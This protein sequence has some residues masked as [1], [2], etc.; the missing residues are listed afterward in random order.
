M[1]LHNGWPIVVLMVGL[2]FALFRLNARGLWGDEVW[3]ASW[4]QQ[5]D[6]PH[7]IL[8][9]SAPPDFPLHF[10]L[11]QI[12]TQFSQDEFWV[13]LPSA[14][15]AA[16]TVLLLYFLGKRQFDRTTGVIAALL[17][18]VA[19]F[20]V[21]YAQE[22]RPYAAQACYSVL[23][24]FFFCELV[25]APSRRA[26]LGLTV[27]TM[28]NLYNQFFALV[29]MLAE[30]V[31]LALLSAWWFWKTRGKVD[32]S[33]QRAIVLRRAILFVT[34]GM[35]A[36]ILALPLVPGY[37][38]YIL[39]RGPGEVEAP[40]FRVTPEFLR[41]IFGLFGS[42]SDWTFWLMA[43]LAVF[44]FLVAFYRRQWFALVALIWLALPFIIL[45]VTQPRH[46]FIPRYFLFVQPVYI[47]MIGFG[48]AQLANLLARV[49]LRWVPDPNSRLG[50]LVPALAYLVLV[51]AAL[52]VMLLQTWQSYW[53]EKTNDWSAVCNYLLTHAQPADAVT[54]DAYIIGLMQWCNP[55][56][57][58]V[59]V[60][61]SL[62]K[63]LAELGTLGLNVW[64]VHIDPGLD[65]DWLKQN[66]TA[67]TRSEWARP[68]LIP[69]R[70]Y[71]GFPFP[72]GEHPAT[73]YYYQ[74]KS[75]SAPSEVVFHEVHGGG[76]TPDYTQVGPQQRNAVRLSLPAK[77]PR[78]LRITYFDL[79]GRDLKISVNGAILLKI[80]AGKSG[81]L[82]VPVD[83]PL[84]ADTPDTF[85]LEFSNPGN[86]IS[87]ISKVQVLYAEDNQ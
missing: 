23:S 80:K 30:G 50:R 62:G 12:T 63:P 51:G 36:V 34:S 47:L 4:S 57:Q 66:A 49:L 67:T 20:H 78:I 82:W 2:A 29:P 87:A 52:V 84:P 85:L 69:A 35:V 10:I 77:S 18:A 75:Q 54:G 27:A 17:L 11:V 1:V 76:N 25:R 79:K 60:F 40:P 3:Q 13:R 72:Q 45:A 21:W 14:L 56:R 86:E 71:S 41:D 46:N 38:S 15:L 37:I 65:V 58:G 42:G 33:Q 7:T 43:S 39:A 24:L 64:Y 5:Q 28:L 31:S 16:V 44:G 48:L 8:R 83:I 22:A 26:W 70:E 61:D 9:F 81:G 74:T 59:A 55:K 19:P 32:G 73:L 53:L 6:L 68:G